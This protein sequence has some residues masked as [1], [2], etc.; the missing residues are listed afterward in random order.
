MFRY[1]RLPFG[2][3]SAPGIFQRV[4][5]SLLQGIEGVVVNLDDILIT[6]S[7]EDA[8]LKPLDEVL[9]KLDDADL[10]VKQAKCEFLKPSVSYLGHR[11]DANGLHPLLDQVQAIK[12]AP[13]PTSVTELKSYLGIIVSFCP[14]FRRP[15]IHCICYFGRMLN[16]S[17]MLPKL[18]PLQLRKSYSPRMSV[19]L[20][21][22]HLSGL[23]S[24][25]MLRHMVLVQCYRTR[26]PMGRRDR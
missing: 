1:T 11:I 7:S 24:H 18:G 12:E 4:I 5:E 17:G 13:T 19:S 9:K 6:G 16:G 22:T 21:S 3:S 8:H 20:I 15:Y 26:C 2:I 25:V 14:T 10:R 23:L